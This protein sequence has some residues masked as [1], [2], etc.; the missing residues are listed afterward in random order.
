MYPLHRRPPLHGKILAGKH[1]TGQQVGR[2]Q[3]HHG[4]EGTPATFEFVAA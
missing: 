1:L 3:E 2:P 4:A